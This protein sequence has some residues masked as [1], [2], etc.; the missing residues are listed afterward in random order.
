MIIGILI[1]FSILFTCI[2]LTYYIFEL[3]QVH[4]LYHKEYQ[5]YVIGVIATAISII[6]MKTSIPFDN[7]IIGDSR[8]ICILFSGLL[9][10]PI[11][12]LISSTLVGLF[13]IF[14]FD[15]SMTSFI[16]GMN[17][18]AIGLVMAFFTAKKPMTQRN[19]HFYLLFIAIEI[20]IVLFILQPN[21]IP[22]IR[23]TIIFLFTIISGFYITFAVMKLF[24]AQFER[25]R[26]I[27]KL[28][29]TDYVTNLPNGRKFQEIFQLALIEQQPFSILIIDIDQFKRFNRIYGHSFGDEIL[30]N[31]ANHLKIFAAANNG[32]AARASGEEFYLLCY[33][34]PPAIGL[35]YATIFTHEISD[36][37]FTLSNNTIVDVTIS[38][39][40][41]SFPDNGKS[42]PELTQ[43]AN[44]ATEF[45]SRNGIAQISHANQIK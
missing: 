21:T 22:A 15:L 25:I 45:A 42:I 35:H 27:E 18:I 33:D 14:A 1:N 29:E 19:I 6:L 36:M 38:I 11:A 7:G 20:M 37:P 44:R 17:L 41:S 40:I 4:R 23:L 43:A 16:S 28:A 3:T 2:I 13:R 12:I 32:Y 5:P 30:L 9:G 10:G 31:L 8:N 39:G 26:T 34:A 24:H